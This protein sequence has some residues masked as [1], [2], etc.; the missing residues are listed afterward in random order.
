MITFIQ[1]YFLKSNFMICIPVVLARETNLELGQ[2]CPI[3]SA[4]LES[5]LKCNSNEL[6][7]FMVVVLIQ[8]FYDYFTSVVSVQASIDFGLTALLE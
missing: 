7:R 5:N 1:L 3:D 8:L 2:P 6:T 4:S